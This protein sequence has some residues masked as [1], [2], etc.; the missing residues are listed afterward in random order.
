MT[1]AGAFV[2]YAAW[3]IIGWWTI[4]LLEPDTNYLTLEQLDQVF[5]KDTSG[6][7]RHG[8]AELRWFIL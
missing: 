1:T 3:C 7:V 5:D 8:L 2:W 6:Y 4:L